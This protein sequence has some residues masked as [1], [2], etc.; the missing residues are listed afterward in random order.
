LTLWFIPFVLGA[1][2]CKALSSD[3]TSPTYVYR[4]SPEEVKRRAKLS[5][6]E[7]A[8]ILEDM[9]QTAFFDEEYERDRIEYE[10]ECKARAQERAQWDAIRRIIHEG[11]RE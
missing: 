10:S 7:D 9:E 3:G 5:A 6:E 8:Q 1:L 4:E 2:A 11:I